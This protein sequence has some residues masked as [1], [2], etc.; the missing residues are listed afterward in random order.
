MIQIVNMKNIQ[1]LLIVI[2]IVKSFSEFAFDKYESSYGD[3]CDRKYDEYK[4]RGYIMKDEELILG[5][6]LKLF[7][8]CSK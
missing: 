8:D 6:L 2:Y 5:L 7:Y 3:Y 4:E 1:I